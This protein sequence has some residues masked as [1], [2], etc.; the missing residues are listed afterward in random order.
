MTMDA[1]T[2]GRKLVHQGG[3]SISPVT[4]ILGAELIPT[5]SSSVCV[6]RNLQQTHHAEFV[7]VACF[8]EVISEK[9]A[10]M[11]LEAAGQVASDEHGADIVSADISL[12]FSQ[13]PE[14]LSSGV[15]DLHLEFGLIDFHPPTVF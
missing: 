14:V 2:D 5:T 10:Y 1:I 3:Q 4:G 6:I 15:L 8:D 13:R 12:E 9:Y 7:A 11:V